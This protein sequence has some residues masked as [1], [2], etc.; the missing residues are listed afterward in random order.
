[1]Q[2]LVYLQIIRLIKQLSRGQKVNLLTWLSTEV[3]QT[4][5]KN[6]FFSFTKSTTLDID[7]F[8][9]KSRF[10][11]SEVEGT[12]FTEMSDEEFNQMAQQL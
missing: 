1:M 12:F 5:T 4:R 8:K 10:Q 6:K 9:E 3:K 2:S 7:S 11:L